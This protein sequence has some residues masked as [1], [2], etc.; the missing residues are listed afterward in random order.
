MIMM[1][2]SVIYIHFL[3][4]NSCKKID[5][6]IFALFSSTGCLV[7]Y[8][9]RTQRAAQQGTPYYLKQEQPRNQ[10][11]VPNRYSHNDGKE[12]AIRANYIDVPSHNPF[13]A[14]TGGL[15][16]SQV[17]NRYSHNDGQ[18]HA[19]RPNYADVLPPESP[20]PF[21]ARTSGLRRNQVPVYTDWLTR[22]GYADRGFSV[23]QTPGMHDA[24]FQHSYPRQQDR[25]MGQNYDLTRWN[26][27]L[28]RHFSGLMEPNETQQIPARTDGARQFQ[29]R[30]TGQLQF[31][32]R[33][34]GPQKYP[35]RSYGKEQYP[36]RPYGPQQ[37]ATRQEVL[38]DT[39]PALR[40]PLRDRRPVTGYADHIPGERLQ[41]ATPQHRYNLYREDFTGN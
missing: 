25:F 8:R 34:N 33:T 21:R 38:Q 30:T 17:P 27:G 13:G 23:D 16:Q 9:Y 28:A 39:H 3:F 19:I 7:Y 32:P 40:S 4:V 29:P 1:S 12:H 26:R 20:D 31:S 5:M 24:K 35:T 2:E 37:F 10:P 15:R 41:F 18:Q 6:K 36:S 22:P 11:H 14:R